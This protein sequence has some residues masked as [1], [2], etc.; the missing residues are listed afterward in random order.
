VYNFYSKKV[1]IIKKYPDIEGDVLFSI[2]IWFSHIFQF[3]ILSAVV[4][5]FIY[6]LKFIYNDKTYWETT[7][8]M[9]L[10]DYG[11][12]IKS[13]IPIHDYKVKLNNFSIINLIKAYYPIFIIS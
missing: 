5:L 11:G 6:Q 12:C 2:F 13:K 4:N 8:A 1:D 3:I 7:K 9:D 10:E